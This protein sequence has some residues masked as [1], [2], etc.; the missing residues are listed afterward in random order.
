MAGSMASMVR[1]AE[2]DVA[3]QEHQQSRND[4]MISNVKSEKLPDPAWLPAGSRQR[5]ALLR[6]S[7]LVGLAVDVVG[8]ILDVIGSELLTEGRHGAVAV[9]DLGDDGLHIVL[10]VLHQGLLLPEPQLDAIE[11]RTFA[12]IVGLLQVIVMSHTGT[13]YRI[14]NYVVL[15]YSESL[16]LVLRLCCCCCCSSHTHT[17]F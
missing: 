4:Q 17:Q 14:S 6:C 12:A 9:G 15:F 3:C 16:R 7:P 10:A 2:A 11:L 5:V 1:L 13:V 8:H